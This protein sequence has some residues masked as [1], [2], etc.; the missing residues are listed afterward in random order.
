MVDNHGDRK[1]SPTW[2]L[3]GVVGPLPNGRTS[4]LINGGDPNHLL[5][6]MILQVDPQNFNKNGNPSPFATACR[7]AGAAPTRLRE[8]MHSE[9]VCQERGLKGSISMHIWHTSSPS[10]GKFFWFWQH[11]GYSR[12]TASKCS[13]M[14]LHCN[15]LMCCCFSADALR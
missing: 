14:V 11:V 2:I 13:L 8:S 6:G 1:S 9:K 3:I 12:Q 15:N 5:T 4:W 7:H 10:I